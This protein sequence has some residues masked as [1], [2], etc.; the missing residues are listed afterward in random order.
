MGVEVIY[1]PFFLS[2]TEYLEGHAGDFDAF[3]ITRYYVAQDILAKIKTHAPRAKV[4]FNNADLHFLREIRAAKAAGDDTLMARARKTRQEELEI[5]GKVDVVLSYNEV[6]HS[7]LEAYTD[8]AARVVKCP[9]VVETVRSVAPLKK[10]AGLSFLGS[11]RH[12]PNAEGIRWFV[13]DVMPVVQDVAGDVPLYIYGSGMPEDIKALAGPAVHP[14]GFVE[15]VADAYDRHRIFV[16]PLLSGAGIKGKV[17]GALAHGI[18]CVVSPTAAEGIGL[19]HK[20]DC[21]IVEK[22]EEWAE[23]IRQLMQDDKTWQSISQ[24]ALAYMRDSFS[25]EVGREKMRQAFEA[26]DMFLSLD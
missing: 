10:R 14:V 17:L 25:F 20:H 26:A 19:R 11:Y 22:P 13:N 4:L 9:W 6:E 15:D 2:P 12:H 8:G 5:I 1:A 16:A 23:A 7:V 3:F 18:P 21:F 24:N